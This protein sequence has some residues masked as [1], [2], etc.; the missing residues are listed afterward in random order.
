MSQ[1]TARRTLGRVGRL[2]RKELVT[3]L[4]DRRTIITLVLMPILLYPLLTIAF[5]QFLLVHG[6]E[7]EEGIVYRVGLA[8]REEARLF[9][10]HYKLGD[11]LLRQKDADGDE[12]PAGI[13][14]LATDQ[15]DRHLRSRDID[16]HVRVRSLHR[17]PPTRPG[18][19]VL[20]ELIALQG[21]PQSQAAKD[22]VERRLQAANSDRLGPAAPDP[23][24]VP[25]G[26]PV[27]FALSSTEVK[28]DAEPRGMAMSA[29]VPLI[30][31]LMT[32]TGAVYPAIDL[33]AG[34]RE[35]GTLEILV[36]APVPRMALL[37]AKYVAVLAIAV[38][39]AV[40]NVVSMTITLQ[41][42]QMGEVVFGK[43]GL[44]PLVI[45]QVLGLLL[46][47]A[48]FFSAVLLTVTS[49]ARSFKE[50]QA[51]LIP[52][53]L[54]SLT[55]GM[56]S[57]LPEVR[58]SGA[59]RVVPLLN[60]VLLT[61]DVLEGKAGVE[62]TALVVATT[63]VYA[64]AAVALAARIFGAEAVLY[65]EQT[66]WGDLFRRPTAPRTA[67]TL[68]AALFCLALLFPVW[69]VVASLI[70]SAGQEASP[71]VLLTWLAAGNVLLFAGVPFVFAW[72]GRVKLWEG[73]R[74][75][76]SS[77]T[78]WGPALFFGLGLWLFALFVEQG[79]RWL[80]VSTLGEE[81]L[82]WV[83][84]D[85]KRWRTVSPVLV[86]LVLAVLPAVLEETFFRGLLLGAL[87]RRVRPHS[88]IVG[89]A[90]FFGLFHLVDRG[91]V[92]VEHA[93]ISAL[94]GVLLGWLAWRSGSILPGI[95]LHATH[96]VCLQLLHY[97]QPQLIE[98]GWLEPDQAGVPTTW[99]L[100]AA[101]AVALGLA[102]AWLALRRLPRPKPEPVAD[103]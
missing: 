15:P 34:E 61:R 86:A 67:L 10:A 52:L 63:L 55:P 39:T 23:I 91:V 9:E 69:F 4:R 83:A 27:V 93:V 57:L 87:L 47:F 85:A 84:A 79:L 71:P 50:A 96:N 78:L 37:F 92:I 88:A 36:A 18:Q 28:P 89:S 100:A 103:R 81:L 38:L 51:Y 5:R 21:S 77:P 82:A 53:M 12:R 46:L 31:I 7:K 75:Q 6:A 24:Q 33:T 95:I 56:L 66:G 102:W 60:I 25:D 11:H 41:V 62:S 44:P 3:V 76:Q 42:S 74:L 2:I 64:L 16:L 20:C 65:S 26:L 59:T 98:A 101:V 45:L 48:V 49:F 22:H 58:L 80:G 13:T 72:L 32:M 1:A 90:A 43:Q 40:I 70:G 35:R 29:M 73:L 99:L 68:P 14:L 97:Y 19:P 94:L 17:F 30:L 54:V 8:T